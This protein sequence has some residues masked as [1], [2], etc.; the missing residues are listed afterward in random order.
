[1]IHWATIDRR[2]WTAI[3]LLIWAGRPAAARYLAATGIGD[4][5]DLDRASRW[6]ASHPP[7]DGEP[8][9]TVYWRAYVHLL[10]R[11]RAAARADLSRVPA[12]AE[13]ERDRA[14]LAAQ[15]D[16]AEGLPTD[17]GPLEAAVRAMEPS[18]ARAV[19]AIEL[20]ALRSQVAWTC[21]EDDVAPMLDA[22]SLVEGRAAG[23]LLRS[24]WLALVVMMTAVWAT[25]WLLLSLL[26]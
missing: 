19:A 9:E 14:E 24:Y 10:L 12:T 25:L 8:A 2:R 5:T 26:G 17:V 21:G 18:V 13:M 15:I 7:E 20:G 1:M 3:E 22:L 6:L 11:D 23:T 16:L 4:P